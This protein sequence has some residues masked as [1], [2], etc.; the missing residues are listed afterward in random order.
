LSRKGTILVID[1]EESMRF[2]LEKTL[3]RSGYVLETASSGREGIERFDAIRPDLVITDLKM[4][5]LD[6][7]EVLERIKERDPGAVV[8]MITGYGTIQNAVEAMKRGAADYLTKPFDTRTI[9]AVVERVFPHR[10]GGGGETAIQLIG[11]SAALTEVMKVVQKVGTTDV[12]VL[13]QG[14][15]GTGKELVARAIHATGGRQHRPFMAV[16]CAALPPTLLE[17]ELLGHTAGAFTGATRHHV[18]MAARAED[19]TLFLDEVGDIPL[20]V[21]A[22]LLRLLQER[23]I[24]PIGASEIIPLRARV[25]SATHRNLTTLIERGDFRE[26]LFYRLN[27]VPITLPPL[28]E[29]PED[30]KPLLLHFLNRFNQA[31]GR[32]VSTFGP[33]ALDILMAY[34]WPG[35]VRELSNL[36]ERIVAMKEAGIVEVEDLPTALVATPPF[37]AAPAT[38]LPFEAARRTFEREFFEDLL[39]KTTGNVSEAARRAGISRPNLY[40]RLKEAGLDP[41]AFKKGA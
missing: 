37:H 33:D 14:E 11:T 25:I 29:R 36:M 28:R 9:R 32:N 22:K 38:H 27:V 12:T 8:V 4:P 35:N 34:V 10:M 5:D 21:Q 17:T 19:G 2:F 1:D 40:R 30:I 15:S 23:E 24:Q 20:P 3:K 13:L 6:G 16:H 41:G 7:V 18:G 39:Q 26:D 31:Q